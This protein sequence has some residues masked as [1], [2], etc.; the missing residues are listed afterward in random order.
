MKKMI[1]GML[2]TAGIG[3]TAMA[4]T[5]GVP[6]TTNPEDSL[7]TTTTIERMYVAPPATTVVVPV[8]TERTFRV[9]YPTASRTVWYRVNDDWYRV[10]Y[11]DNGPWLW[12]GYNTRGE[13]YPISLPVLQTSV[14]SSVVDNVTNKYASV[15]DITET[16]GSD[17]QTQYIVRTIENG[18]VKSM[19]V[20]AGGEQVQP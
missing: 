20:N 7:V 11:I 16:I 19:R 15:Y 2:F 13:S 8:Y 14:P 5:A 3:M 9:H 4:Q 1:L 17:M 10:A 18:E 12:L 6:V